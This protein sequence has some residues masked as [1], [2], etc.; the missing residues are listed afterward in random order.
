MKPAKPV[1]AALPGTPYAAA[2]GSAHTVILTGQSH[3]RK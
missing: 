1:K 2:C 3:N